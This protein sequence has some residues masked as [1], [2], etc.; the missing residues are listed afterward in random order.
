M[1]RFGIL[2]AVA[3]A[4][5]VIL[6]AI[7]ISTANHN[8]GTSLP[9]TS[10]QST[11]PAQNP[12]SN[13]TTPGSNSTS[14]GPNLTI[15][16]GG[17]G[18]ACPMLFYL[19]SGSVTGYT[20]LSMYT[21]NSSFGTYKDYVLAPGSSG[22]LNITEHLSNVLEEP[23]NS[24]ILSRQHYVTLSLEGNGT[25]TTGASAVPGV[26]TSIMPQNY[27]VNANETLSFTI[28]VTA[29]STAK[30]TYWTR[31]DGPCGEGLYP[32]FITVG[33]GPYNGTVTP[34]V[35]TFA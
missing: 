1:N 19:V 24:P 12:S 28:T 29:N 22:T 15:S 31:V 21:L 34:V 3:V 6:A 4:V 35:S 32:F 23:A 11:T 2:G 17:G 16:S 25:S 26:E 20:G 10:T 18:L 33:N 5:I 14:T 8:V 7:G 13:T 27:T 30:G 9:T